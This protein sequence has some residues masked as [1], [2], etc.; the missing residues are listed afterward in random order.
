MN[1]A[2]AHYSTFVDLFDAK[3]RIAKA[4]VESIFRRARYDIRPFR[5]EAT[6]LRIGREDLSPDFAVARVAD[7]GGDFLLDVKY[8]TSVEQFVAMEV[9]RG[10]RSTLAMARRQW[11]ALRFVLVTDRPE[12]HRSCFQALSPD[13]PLAG[14]PIHTVD[15]GEASEL[16][17]FPHN[18]ADH[19][20]LLRRIFGLLSEGR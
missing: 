13:Q 6:A 19:E 9:Q 20:Q 15:L 12:P 3:S 1:I 7:A 5:T 11:P 2:S 10:D 18:V 16:G 4:L 14:S 8:R 17:I